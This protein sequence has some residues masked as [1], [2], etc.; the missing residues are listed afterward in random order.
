MLAHAQE[1]IQVDELFNEIKTLDVSVQKQRMSAIQPGTRILFPNDSENPSGI[2]LG[3][4]L[5]GNGMSAIYEVLSP[6]T[7]EVIKLP[8]FV[9]DDPE[10]CS[11]PYLDAFADGA[12]LLKKYAI[13]SVTLTHH[14]RGYYAGVSRLPRDA[15]TLDDMETYNLE[16]KRKVLKAIIDFSIQT[17]AFDNIGDLKYN[18]FHYSPSQEKIIL[19]DW[20]DLREDRQQYH[21]L[22]DPDQRIGIEYNANAKLFFS[23]LGLERSPSGIRAIADQHSPFFADLTLNERIEAANQMEQGIISE[24]RRLVQS[25]EFR[26]DAAKF[27]FVGEDFP[28]NLL[29]TERRTAILKKQNTVIDLRPKSSSSCRIKLEQDH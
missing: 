10:L 6:P 27:K 14:H 5:G 13:E 15:V 22:F 21:T 24:R 12:A 26:S 4:Y 11:R 7:M 3:K 19:A 16:Q 20:A 2:T 9:N 8:R 17:A 29:A 1:T 18:D 23:L 28:V 25:T